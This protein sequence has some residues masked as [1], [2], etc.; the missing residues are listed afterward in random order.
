[1]NIGAQLGEIAS[2]GGFFG[3]TVGGD[4]TGW[5]P[6]QRCYDGGCVDLVGATAA[7]YDTTDLRIG[8][9]L[10]QFSHASRLWS[11]LLACA[12]QYGVLPDLTDLQR[13]ASGTELRLP[14]PFGG[15]VDGGGPMVRQLY[16]LVITDHLEP[17]AAG[18]RVK[19]APRLLY[20]NAAAAL[21]AA[22]HDV[23]RARPD[24]IDDVLGVTESLLVS[25]ELAG[26]GHLTGWAF[27]RRSCCLY[28]RVPGGSNCGDCALTRPRG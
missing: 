2:R 24:L 3:I 16:R 5:I 18:F 20:G 26:T 27:R 6:V 4:P 15:P 1:M 9:S 28:Y 11:P 10:V 7:R 14:V 21:V 23:V 22:A 8:A 17:L 12:L 19:M 25:G 13:H